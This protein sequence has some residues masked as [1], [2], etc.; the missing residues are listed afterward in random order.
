M[1][2]PRALRALVWPVFGLL[3]VGLFAMPVAA[4]QPET[5]VSP[6]VEAVGGM[7]I[8]LISAVG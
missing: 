7:V 1:R 3:A 8:T 6:V 2:R 4:Q 5:G